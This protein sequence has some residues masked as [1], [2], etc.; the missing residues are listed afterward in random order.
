MVT[1]L[2]FENPVF[3]SYAFYGTLVLLK[4][5]AMIFLTIRW[6]FKNLSFANPEDSRAFGVKKGQVKFD[7]QDVERVRR[8]HLNDMEN[9]PVFLF[10]GLLYVLINPSPVIALWHFRVFAASRFIHTFVYQFAIPQPSR[11]LSFAVGVAVCAS[12]AVQVL[13]HTCK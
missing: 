9:I 13:M 12:M 3:S 10:L 4:M 1:Q 7:D 2:G 11:A 8:N 5:M 6:R